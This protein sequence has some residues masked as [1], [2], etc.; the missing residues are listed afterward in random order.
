[1]EIA[2]ESAGKNARRLIEDLTG[3]RLRRKLF[4]APFALRRSVAEE[5]V[6]QYRDVV[7]ET[8][9]S[10]FRRMSDVTVAGALHMYYA[11]ATGRAVRSRIR[12][13]Y[14]NVQA[15][16]I[17]VRLRRMLA[18]DRY[19]VFC[20]NDTADSAE[21]TSADSSAEVGRRARDFLEAYFPNVSSYER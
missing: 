7:A 2:S 3:R 13:R 5:I 1:G 8:T 20:L 19:D 9:R 16:D 14:L 10:V 15:P 18:H 17:D 21:E 11:L 12:Y 4:H 6:E